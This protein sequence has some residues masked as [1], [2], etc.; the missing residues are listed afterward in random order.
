LGCTGKIHETTD[1]GG[2]AVREL[3][4]STHTH[5]ERD[6]R[7]RVGQPTAL[8]RRRVAWD[9]AVR[10]EESEWAGKRER[11]VGEGGGG[12]PREGQ[13]WVRKEAGGGRKGMGDKRGASIANHT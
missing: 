6:P 13:C 7:V 3:F 4:R 1:C 11:D 9:G 8:A 5:R 10:E 2:F 12:G